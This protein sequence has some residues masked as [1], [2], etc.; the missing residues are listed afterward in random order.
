MMTDRLLKNF[1]KTFKYINDEVQTTVYPAVNPLISLSIPSD[2]NQEIEN[3][4][5]ADQR[6][7]IRHHG[8]ALHFQLHKVLYS[9]TSVGGRETLQRPHSL[10]D[11]DDT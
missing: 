1:K 7:N 9:Q 6:K 5:G 3:F 2:L 4:L 8:A 11:D 10:S